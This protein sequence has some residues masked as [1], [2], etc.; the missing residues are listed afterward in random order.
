MNVFK[1]EKFNKEISDEELENDTED[2]TI[3]SILKIIGIIIAIIGIICGIII[4]SD[5]EIFTGVVLIIASILSAIFAY[6]F[7]EIIQLLE[8]IYW[9]LDEY[10]GNNNGTN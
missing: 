9:K 6:G 8:D 5:E 10:G 7:G 1:S 4:I 2:N 3:A